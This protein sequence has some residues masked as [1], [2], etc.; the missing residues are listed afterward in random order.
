MAKINAKI[1]VGIEVPLLP[2]E[3][4]FCR[5][6][7]EQ[8]S[9][10]ARGNGV[11]D[12]KMGSQDG[13]EGDIMGFTAEYAFAKHFNVFPDL[14]LVPRSGSADGV[15]KG[16]RYDVKASEYE[17]AR[18]LSTLKVNPDV[19]IYALCVVRDNVVEIKGWAKKDELIREDNKT[20]LGYGQ[21]YALPQNRLRKFKENES[22]DCRCG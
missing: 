3:I 5:Y 17:N 22:G 20:N 8:R 15:L 12:A 7:G 6:I 11:F 18:L 10:V 2:D 21:G 16:Y 19:D 1:S 14:G 4:E 9:L 13:V